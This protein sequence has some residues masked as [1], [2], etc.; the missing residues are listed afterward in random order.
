MFSFHM[1]TFSA[2]SDISEDISLVPI[3]RKSQ[4]SARAIPANGS[5]DGPS[6][7]EET[8]TADRMGRM[9]QDDSVWRTSGVCGLEASTDDQ[10]GARSPRKMSQPS[11]NFS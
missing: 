10:P 11:T 3:Y 8:T 6:S 4:V 7:T 9:E 2:K 1:K 5:R